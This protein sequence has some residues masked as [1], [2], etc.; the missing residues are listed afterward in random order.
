MDVTSSDAARFEDPGTG[1]GAGDAGTGTGAGT[2]AGTG[3]CATERTKQ[4]P[5]LGPPSSGCQPN[6]PPVLLPFVQ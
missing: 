3:D 5:P 4:D 6:P 2:G 1:D